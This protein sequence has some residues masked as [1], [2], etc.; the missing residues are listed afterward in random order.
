MV[1]I[2]CLLGHGLGVELLGWVGVVAGIDVA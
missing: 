2:L 1:R